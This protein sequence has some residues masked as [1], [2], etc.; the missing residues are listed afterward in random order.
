LF[1][2][3]L[4]K[5]D[6][7]FARRTAEARRGR[8]EEFLTEFTGFWNRINGNF[9]DRIHGIGRIGGRQAELLAELTEGEGFALRAEEREAE[10]NFDRRNMK[11]LQGRQGNFG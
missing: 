6:G 2:A 11:N 10:K 5:T 1:Y 3:F 7:D 9:L 4:K 8:Q